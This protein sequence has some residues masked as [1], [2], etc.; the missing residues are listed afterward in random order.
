[1]ARQPVVVSRSRGGTFCLWFFALTG[2]ELPVFCEVPHLLGQQT[3]CL[4]PRPAQLAFCRACVQPIVAFYERKLAN[5]EVE[6]T[7]LRELAICTDSI[8]MV[9]HYLC[10]VRRIFPHALWENGR[11]VFIRKRCVYYSNKSGYL[12][13]LFSVLLPRFMCLEVFVL[14]D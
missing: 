7:I 9:E 1:M 3:H 2:C 8:S 13:V 6:K 5:N 14:C 10:L 12:P 4:G 11:A